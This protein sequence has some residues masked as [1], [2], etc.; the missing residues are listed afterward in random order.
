MLAGAGDLRAQRRRAVGDPG[1]AQLP[2]IFGHAHQHAAVPVQVH[3]DDLPAVVVFHLGLPYLVETDALHL[4]A[5][6][7]SGGPLLHRI[8]GPAVVGD[9]FA[10]T[11]DH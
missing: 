11:D 5:S 10:H 6:A 3:T 4:P 2:A 1:G 8:R 9:L 7:R